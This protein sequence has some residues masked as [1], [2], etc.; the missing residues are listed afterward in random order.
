MKVKGFLLIGAAGAAMAPG[1]QAADMMVKAPPPAMPAPS[2][3][4]LYIGVHAGAVLQ[5]ADQTYG[6]N[7]PNPHSIGA[8]TDTGFIGGGQIGYNFQTGNFVYGI[9]GDFSGLSGKAN[10]GTGTLN[11][12]SLNPG[13]Y[14]GQISWLA[15][16]RGRVGVA[17]GDTMPYFTAGL[18]ISHAKNSGNLG[19]SGPTDTYTDSSTRTGWVVGGGIEHMITRNWTVKFEGL[20]V[21][22]GS[23][24]VEIG[25]NP[26]SGKATKFNNHLVIARAGLNFKF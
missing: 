5:G 4:G 3:T 9:E 14:T 10:I 13:G 23:K 1:A 24:V 6:F 12:G 19:F 7:S 17:I 2:W 16:V 15:T 22:A 20:W 8:A 25:S 11:V 21:D 18:A 26:G